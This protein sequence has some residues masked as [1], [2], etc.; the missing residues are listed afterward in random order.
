VSTA[1]LGGNGAHSVDS[2]THASAD[3]ARLVFATAE[4]LVAED[5]DTAIDVYRWAD[6]QTTLVSDRV[7][8][9][10]DEGL[11]AF[12]FAASRDGARVIFTTFEPLV[13]GD[14]DAS[15]D[16]YQWAG[17]EVTLVSDRVQAGADEE[18]EAN[19]GGSSADGTHIFFITDEPLV[20][21][22]G[23]ASQ[24]AY[25]WAAGQTTLVSDRVK[26]GA[27][28]ERDAQ[29]RGASA[30]GT[31]AFFLTTEQLV[32]DDTDASRD[33]YQRAGGQTALVSDRV[34]AGADGAFNASFRAASPNGA[35]VVF[36]TFE[37]LVEADGDLEE[38]VYERTGGETTLLSDRIQ[39]GPD[40]AFEPV[41]FAGTSADGRRVFFTTGEPLV[42]AD[43]DTAEDVYERAG[44]ETTL[45]SDRLGGGDDS[46][47]PASFSSA[48]ADGT[49]VFLTTSEPLLPEDGDTNRDV[50]RTRAL[51]RPP[52]DDPAPD[53]DAPGP[54]PS[55]PPLDSPPAGAAVDVSPPS[56]TRVRVTR[57]RVRFV[58]SEAA[59]VSIAIA[60]RL[61]GRR[62]PILRT[63][64]R[65]AR[66][67]L[68]SVRF[69]RR[70]RRRLRPGRYVV[71]LVATDAAG[72]SSLPV[73]RRFRIARA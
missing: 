31:H 42:T 35:R 55:P 30:D 16:L 37:P 36:T 34:Q 50:Y 52:A 27:D 59:S 38:D 5:G 68:N 46:G 69:T 63:L 73:R 62:S 23:D 64:E 28:E 29:V 33:V 66:A 67:G 58:V 41:A 51:P 56:L 7:Q 17:G 3:G 15:R 9:G 2:R 11:P 43:E 14:G 18:F 20:G 70:L 49:R 13:S 12:A 53:L 32:S 39:P 48:S 45:L 61:P 65:S 57:K 44:S 1:A 71:T 8:P 72:N 10:S 26:P 25:E 54:V 19:F 6:G 4:Q 47:F 24:D 22:D 60:R 40:A 21:E